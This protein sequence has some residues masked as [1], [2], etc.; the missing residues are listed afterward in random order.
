MYDVI[1][2][3][4]GPAG[5]TAAI[6]ACRAG[7]TCAVI[8]R[9]LVGGMINDSAKVENIPG[10]I[11]IS[12]NDFATQLADQAEACGTEIIYDEVINVLFDKVFYVQAEKYTYKS[13]SVIVATGT[14]HNVLGLAGEED[15]IGNGVHFCAL[16]DGA[17]YKDK[18]VVVVG[19]GNSALTE[20]LYLSDICKNVTILQNLSTLTGDQVLINRINSTNNIKVVTNCNILNY[21]TCDK[22]LK[23]IDYKTDPNSETIRSWCDGVFL[24]IGLSPNPDP[25]NGLLEYDDRGYITDSKVQGIFYAGDCSSDTEVKQVATACASGAV[26][27]TRACNYLRN[28]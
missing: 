11:E 3:G 19:G 4:G 24:C 27:A 9:D 7:K 23:A 1:V 25:T 21:F 10:F 5:L 13:K 26:A 6:Y 14:K 18:D 2:I 12:G 16:C 22:K 20:A 15:L 8:E 17:F 28:Q